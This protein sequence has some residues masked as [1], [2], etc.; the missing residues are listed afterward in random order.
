MSHKS[1]SNYG[2]RRNMSLWQR[3]TEP[4]L[5]PLICL[6]SVVVF[7][8]VSVWVWKEVEGTEIEV[9]KEEIRQLKEEKTG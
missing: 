5:S 1:R 3:L 9:L 8:F 7:S 4:S 6:I 2:T